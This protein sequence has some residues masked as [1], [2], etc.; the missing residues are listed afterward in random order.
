MGTGEDPSGKVILSEDLREGHAQG[1]R[2][3][4][5]RARR[6]VWPG[7]RQRGEVWDTGSGCAGHSRPGTWA[8][9][10]TQ[11]LSRGVMWVT[12]VFKVSPWLR[13]GQPARGLAVDGCCVPAGCAPLGTGETV[14]TRTG[15]LRPQCLRRS[16]A[17]AASI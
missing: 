16:R 6:Q 15:H 17:A 3:V 4:R 10:I 5:E 11:C 7:Q 12:C 1:Q 14:Q 8:S 2:E 13:S 9:T